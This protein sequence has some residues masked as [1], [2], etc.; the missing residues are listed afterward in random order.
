VSAAARLTARGRALLGCGLAA[1]VFARLFGSQEVALLGAVLVAAVVVARAWIALAGGPHVALRTLPPFAHAGEHVHVAVELRPLEGARSGRA[2]FREAGA[3]PVCALRPVSAGGLRVLRGSYELGPLERGLLELGAAELVREDPFGLARR[4]DATRG[5]T[6]LTVI[7]PPLQLHDVALGAG[8]DIAAARRRLRG[9]GHELHGVRE[10]QPGESL[11]GVHWPATAHRGRLM[12]K[13]LDDPGGDELAVVLDARASADLGTAPDSSFEL[14][15]AAAG[16][17]VTQAQADGRRVRLLVAGPE[18]EPA[19]AAERAAVRR[20][21]ARARPAGERRPGDLLSRIAAERIEVVTTRPADLLGA[22]SARRLGVVAID[23]SSFDEAVPRDAHALAALQ[24]AGARVQEL[25]RPD[26]PSASEPEARPERPV[27]WP[28]L[29]TGCA[30]AFGLWHVRDL[31]IPALSTSRLAAIAALAVLPAVVALRAGRRLVLVALAPAALVAAWLAAGHWPSP[32]APLGGLSGLLAD[33]PSAWVQVVL[34]F[35]AGERPEL[36]AAVLLALFGWLALLAWFALARP[37]PLAA[38]LLAVAPF[39]LSATVYSLPQYPWRAFA[40]GALLLA[41]LF[42]GLAAGGGRAIAVVLGTLALLGGAAA[43]ALPAASGPALLPWTTWTFSHEGGDSAGVNLVWDMRYQPLSFGPKPVEVLQVRSKRPSYWRALVLSDFDGLRFVRQPQASIA[44]RERGGVVRVPGAP[45]GTALRAQV[46]VEAL[47]G[48]FLVAPGQPVRY[49]LPAEA[50]AV[51]LSEDATATLRVALPEGLG[52]VSEGIDPNPSAQ[53]LRSLPARY[54]ESLGVSDLGFAGQVLPA[55]ATSDRERDLAA[56]FASHRGDPVWDTWRVAYARARA[57]TRGSASPYQTMVALEAWLR[58]TRA[59]DDQ[60]S[61]PDRPDALARWAATGTAGYCQMFA[62]SLA[63]LARLSGIPARV[64]EGFAQGDLRGGVYHVTDRDAHAWVEA[65]FPG[66]GW[67]PFDATPGRDLPQRASSSSAAFDGAAA[68]A[69]AVGNS[70]SSG[71][72]QLPLTRL[73]TVLATGASGRTSS[74]RSPWWTRLALVLGA[75]AALFAALVLLKRVLL[76]LSLPRDPVRRARG[77]VRAFAADQDVE[78]GPA[79]TPR[80][81]AGAVERRFGVG[82]EA[83]A[84]AL[85]RSAYGRPGGRDDVALTHETNGL[86]R[87]LRRAIGRRRRLR[88]LFSVS[89]LR[90]RAR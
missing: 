31:Q 78:L 2:A 3:G 13:E 84:A 68:Q 88:G 66:Y 69:P 55:F 53:A 61:L 52:Y 64:A 21:L 8:G 54:P 83:F 74:G 43:A 65:W 36:R 33:A 58:T 89:A 18:G 86:L 15:V 24:A 79:L 80:E 76:R 6:A 57:V 62:A 85:E 41:F 14:A 73:R 12:V 59:Y 1:L 29:L 63:A 30:G 75:A 40:A 82:T 87:A 7:A 16:A 39:V 60:V 49:E 56:L 38:A 19:S 51:D 28:A 4:V 50:G 48:S 20:L 35:A 46:Q 77:K 47:A 5:T 22:V 70:G 11:R 27:R 71:Q 44:T 45:A 81:L 72:L 42:T 90:G 34:P 9:G 37:R 17:L 26:S 32:G 67:L 25:R 23:P 10:H